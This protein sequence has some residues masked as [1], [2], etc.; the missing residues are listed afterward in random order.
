MARQKIIVATRASLL[1]KTQTNQV[2]AQMNK[3][4][5]ELEFKLLQ[6][7]TTGDR[8]TDKPLRDFGGTG[9][10]VKELENALLGREADV[11]IHSLKDVPYAMTAGLELICFPQ[12]HNPFDLFLTNGALDTNLERAKIV[13]GTSSERRQLQIAQIAPNAVFKDLRGNIDTRMQKL[14]NGDY[15]A[16]I[17]AAAGLERLGKK[18]P[19]SALLSVANCVPAVAQGALVIQARAN[20]SELKEIFSALN[21]ATT[22]AAVEAE[23]EYMGVL[24]GGCRL[25]LGAY[26]E[27]NDGAYTMFFSAGDLKKNVHVR[28]TLQLPESELMSAARNGALRMKRE[29]AIQ[30]VSF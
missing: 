11:A 26:C 22:Q 20:D 30:G 6:I 21:H 24:E 1:A 3:L 10:F 23:R 8:I 5:P 29:L 19:D 14:E 4:Y 18:F 16:I 7:S 28:F 2:L 27:L 25:P 12:R 13:I 17:L 9:V 15:D